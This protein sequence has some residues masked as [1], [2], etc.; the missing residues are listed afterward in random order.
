MLD[1][2]PPLAVQQK[3][4]RHIDIRTTMNVYGDVMTNQEGEALAKI[5]SL[6]LAN[7]SQDRLT[8]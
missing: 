4:M 1:I 6:T 7:S 3:L 5:A 2:S 8:Y